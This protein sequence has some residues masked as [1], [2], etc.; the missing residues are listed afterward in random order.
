MLA[1]SL[2]LSGYSAALANASAARL[3]VE[4]LAVERPLV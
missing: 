3:R 2:T 1:M 4:Q